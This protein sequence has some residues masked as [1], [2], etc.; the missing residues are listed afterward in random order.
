MCHKDNRM[1]SLAAEKD[2]KIVNLYLKRRKTID[3]LEKI[4]KICKC[5]E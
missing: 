5:K 1:Y 4:I 2:L 3:F